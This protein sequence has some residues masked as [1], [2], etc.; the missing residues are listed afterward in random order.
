MA[1]SGYSVQAAAEG[2]Y[3]DEGIQVADLISWDRMMKVKELIY[4]THMDN[5]RVLKV[6][7]LMKCLNEIQLLCGT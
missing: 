3:E 4:K 6:K 2:E 1:F 5:T 7:D